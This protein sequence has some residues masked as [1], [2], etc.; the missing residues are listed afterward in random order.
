LIT[1][2][3]TYGENSKQLQ[4]ANLNSDYELKVL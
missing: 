3:S 1:N 2:T 4:F